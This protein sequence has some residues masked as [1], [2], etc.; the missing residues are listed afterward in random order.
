MV[1]TRMLL[2]R[3]PSLLASCLLLPTI[4]AHGVLKTPAPRTDMGA[5]QGGG[6]GQKLTPQLTTSPNAA[7]EKNACHLSNTPTFSKIGNVRHTYATGDTIRVTWDITLEHTAAPGVRIAVRDTA[8]NIP[9]S[10]HVLTQGTNGFVLND[11]DGNPVGARGEHTLTVTLP[12]GLTCACCQLQWIWDSTS[13]GGFYVD[14]SDISIATGATNAA[15]N[16]PACPNVGQAIPGPGTGASAA[17]GAAGVAPGEEGG[18][19]GRIIIVVIILI[20]VAGG[21]YYYYI[22]KM[23]N[24]GGE[25]AGPKALP[26]V[27]P[28]PAGAPTAPAAFRPP[29]PA[30]RAALPA[31]GTAGFDYAA[32][33]ADQLSMQKGDRVVL[34]PTQPAGGGDWLLVTVNGNPTQGYVPKTYV[35]MSGGQP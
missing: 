9:F 12:A 6:L 27:A 5:T 22:T 8:Q 34:Q 19:S 20:M 1:S 15:V 31:E 24:V 16:G 13:D 17:G 21:G 11:N 14:C 29:V 26:P 10:Q 3:M 7:T 18:S 2:G 32:L 28:A 33:T 23:K 25:P 4:L 30:P 35:V